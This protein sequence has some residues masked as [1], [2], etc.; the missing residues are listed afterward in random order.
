LTGFIVIN[1]N[2][3]WSFCH[4]LTESVVIQLLSWGDTRIV[5]RACSTVSDI[6]CT[7]FGD[8]PPVGRKYLIAWAIS[9]VIEG[10][11]FLRLKRNAVLLNV[12]C[13]FL[14]NTASTLILILPSFRFA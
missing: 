13:A 7:T 3:F 2:L 14:A 11:I 12:L 6:D 5:W 9:I 1:H 10:L 4:R 8:D